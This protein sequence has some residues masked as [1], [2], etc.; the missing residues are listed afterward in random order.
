MAARIGERDD[1]GW[2][3]ATTDDRSPLDRFPQ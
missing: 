2:Q 1:R 3:P